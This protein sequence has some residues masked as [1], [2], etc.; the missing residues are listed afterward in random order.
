[1]IDAAAITR[2]PH[3]PA[4]AIFTRRGDVDLSALFGP[5]PRSGHDL[6]RLA[7]ER[8]PEPTRRERSLSVLLPFWRGLRL[9]DASLESLALIEDPR[10]HM[11]IAGQQ[12]AIGGGPLHLFVKALSAARLARYLRH[13]GVRA[14]PIFWIADEDHDVAELFSGSFLGAEDRPSV[15]FAAGRTPISALRLEISDRDDWIDQMAR[16]LPESPHRDALI[17]TCSRS[18]DPAPGVWFRNLLLALLPGEGLLPVHPS[19]LK[20]LQVELLGPDIELP[21][22]L[23]EQ[24]EPIVRRMEA[25]GLPVPIPKVSVPPLFWIGEDG[26]RHRLE[27]TD[28]GYRSKDGS[29]SFTAESLRAQ[30]AA[31]PQRFSPDA[32]LRPLLQDALLEPFANV[33][34]PT[35]FAYHMQ[36]ADAY[37]QRSIPRPLIIPRMRVRIMDRAERD[38]VEAIG[39]S[40]DAVAASSL[41]IEEVVPSRAANALAATLAEQA[42]PLL[43][44]AAGLEADPQS[45][46]ALRKRLDR[47][48]RRWVDDVEKLAQVIRRDSARDVADER[49]DLERIHQDLY[50]GGRDAERTRSVFHFL[51]R[52]GSDLL[53][54]IGAAFDPGDDRVAL[55]A[56]PRTD[57][58]ARGRR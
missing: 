25:A 57:E 13:L 11:V 50:P 21:D 27:A 2:L 28:D 10:T 15:P 37:R 51:G 34:G 47:L 55:F 44:F 17:E 22:L 4:D 38:R 1:M 58:E 12:P 42:R 52:Y 35:E 39:V 30:F 45:T 29:R 40:L 46:P 23:A 49:R 33:V 32:L 16:L 31:D 26:G 9:P 53:E 6:T 54:V 19:V 18:F 24:V 14:V 5:V 41:D 3:R 48:R 36:L 43:E 56:L 20:P 8:N 7:L